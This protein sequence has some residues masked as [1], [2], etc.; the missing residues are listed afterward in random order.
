CSSHASSLWQKDDEFLINIEDNKFNRTKVPLFKDKYQ[1]SP[2]EL[3]N[4][5]CISFAQTEAML[6]PE[7]RKFIH[8]MKPHARNN[9]LDL[10]TNAS[11]YVEDDFLTEILNFNEVSLTFTV[12]GLNDRHHYLRYPLYWESVDKNIRRW[13][14][15]AVKNPHLVLMARLTL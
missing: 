10:V 4:F 2:E 5:R 14:Q 9:R 12:D 11:Y 6:S 1:W 7:F 8:L 3:E 15:V 13:I